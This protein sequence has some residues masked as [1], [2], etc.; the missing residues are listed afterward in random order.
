[1]IQHEEARPEMDDL[2]HDYFK[3]EM[4]NPFPAF[5]APLPARTKRPVSFWSRYSGRLALAACIALLAAGYMSVASYF[6][7]LNDSAGIHQVAPDIGKKD[8]GNKF[9]P[10]SFDEEPVPMPTPVGNK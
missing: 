1:M 7:R 5:Q 2:L 3:A 4:P 9:V 6:P 10:P 8:K